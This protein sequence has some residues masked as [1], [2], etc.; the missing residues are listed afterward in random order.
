[1][2]FKNITRRVE[3]APYL[4]STFTPPGAAGCLPPSPANAI[5]REVRGSG[6][7]WALLESGIFADPHGAALD[8][9]VGKETKIVWRRSGQGDLQLS[10]IVPDG[11]IVGPERIEAHGGSNWRRPG[12]E[13]GSV[14]TF[15]KP[16]C[17]Q[18]HAERAGG[19][20]DIWLLVRS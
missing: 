13:W 1:L 11:G 7:L 19:T 10:A 20:A 18:L 16:G 9:V 8:D 5:T 17:W 3:V 2:A 12:D 14:F 15:S 6:T 4:E